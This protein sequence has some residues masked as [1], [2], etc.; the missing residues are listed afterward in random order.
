MKIISNNDYQD[1]ISDRNKVR[2]LSKEIIRLKKEN[3]KLK[4]DFVSRYKYVITGE[5]CG[6]TNFVHLYIDGKDIPIR[7]SLIFNGSIDGITVEIND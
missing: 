1:F 7:K 2:E 3:G 4:E 6:M 5:E